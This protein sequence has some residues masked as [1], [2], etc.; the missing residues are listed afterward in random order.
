[1]TQVR[2]AI[3]DVLDRLS[4]GDMIAMGGPARLTK[5]AKPAAPKSS[6]G[7]ARHPQSRPAAKARA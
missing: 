3:S 2:Y 1:M 4:V 7:K 6:G 5:I